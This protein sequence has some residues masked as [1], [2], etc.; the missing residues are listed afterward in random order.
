MKTGWAAEPVDLADEMKAKSPSTPRYA[1]EEQRWNQKKKVRLI[2]DIRASAVNAI[3][4]TGD[5][6]VPENLGGC[7]SIAAFYRLPKPGSWVKIGTSDFP[8]AYKHSTITED[9]K[10]SAAILADPPSGALKV[11]TLRTQPFDSKRAPPNWARVTN[12][13]KRMLLT[14]FRIAILVYA[15]DIFI[16]ETT[17]TIESVFDIA[18]FVLQAIRFAL[19]EIKEQIPPSRLTLL[20]PEVQ[21]SDETITAR[22]PDRGKRELLNEL[23]QIPT[24]GAPT[25]AQS[26]KLRGRLGYSQSLL[27][28]GF[29][30]GLLA[31]FTAMRYSDDTTRF[32]P[33]TDQMRQA[34][35]RRAG[36]PKSTVPRRVS[37]VPRRP[38]LIYADASGPG[39]IGIVTISNGRRKTSHT[40]LHG[41]R[42]EWGGIYEFELAGAIHALVP[43][44]VLAPG[45]PVLL[46][47]DNNSAA[48]AIVRGN[49]P[50]VMGGPPRPRFRPLR[51][52]TSH[53]CGRGKCEASLISPIRRHV[54]A[55]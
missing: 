53:L 15:G 28:G 44:S 26:A 32:H 3:V 33:I 48:A 30:R 43:A 17:E 29:G 41:R 49:C 24:K 11:A 36:I 47:G 20:G 42:L 31:D 21:I 22:L 51:P 7:F 27:F 14:V 4:Q 45:R 8:R 55:T 52:S 39:H 10:E 18:K 35:K 12:F 9:R 5:T 2:D 6:N 54:P 23:N 38:I 34:I 16:I 46:C 19:W 1:I 40:H 13:I 50:S 25:P 37:L